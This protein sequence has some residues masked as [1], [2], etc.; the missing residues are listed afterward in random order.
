[1]SIGLMLG[2]EEEKKNREEVL[3][4]IDLH[5]VFR[6]FSFFVLPFSLALCLSLFTNSSIDTPLEKTNNN[7]NNNNIKK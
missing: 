5:Q 6:F 4:V 1:V 3:V 7:N 2:K